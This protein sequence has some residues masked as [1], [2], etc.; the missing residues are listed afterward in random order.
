MNDAVC[1]HINFLDIYSNFHELIRFSTFKDRRRFR[2]D[3]ATCQS[4]KT[5]SS[6]F[7]KMN[8]TSFQTESISKIVLD[9]SV[10]IFDNALH[11]FLC[12]AKIERFCSFCI[13]ILKQCNIFSYFFIFFLLSFSLLSFPSCFSFSSHFC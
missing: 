5:N 13:F 9:L 4:F 6:L 3:N 10:L 7:L 12:M 2:V 1:L 11:C 8:V